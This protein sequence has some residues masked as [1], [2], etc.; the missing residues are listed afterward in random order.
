MKH[1]I[2]YI[3]I[4]ILFIDFDFTVLV[5]GGRIAS[6]TALALLIIGAGVVITLLLRGA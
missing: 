6:L 1:D 2:I 4:A 3:I 5:Y